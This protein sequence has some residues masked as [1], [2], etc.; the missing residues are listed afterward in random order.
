MS[1]P[2][3]H[4]SRRRARANPARRTISSILLTG[5]TNTSTNLCLTNE[6]GTSFAAPRIAAAIAVKAHAEQIDVREAARRLVAGSPALP[7]GGTMF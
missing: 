7:D 4:L 1:A 6:V 5:C 3:T 2:H